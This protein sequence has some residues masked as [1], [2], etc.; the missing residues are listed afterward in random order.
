[1]AQVRGMQSTGTVGNPD[2]PLVTVSYQ[3]GSLEREWVR[4]DE[5]GVPHL[6]LGDK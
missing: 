1:M 4:V 3:W 5:P 2:Q 6:A